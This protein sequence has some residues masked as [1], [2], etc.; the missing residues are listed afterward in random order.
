MLRDCE[1]WV[2]RTSFFLGVEG[3]K[4][5]QDFGVNANLGGR[6]AVNTAVPVFDDGI[7]VQIGTA[8]NATANAVR[9]NELLGE[10]RDRFQNYST[11]GLFQRTDWGWNWG[12]GYDFLHQRSYDD[13]DL[14]QLRLRT[15]WQWG[16]CDEFGVAASIPLNA[17]RGA[18]GA[19]DV[20]LQAISQQTLFWRH[21]WQSGTTTTVWGGSADGHSEDNA[22]TGF[23]PS[24]GAV[25]VAG[26][27][28]TAPLNDYFSLYG[29]TNL[30]MPPDTGTVDAFL[31]VEVYLSPPT[32]GGLFR[33]RLSPYLPL[34]GS[35]SFPVDLRRR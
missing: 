30:M 20:E 14:S 16:D 9:V 35:T 33:H 13:F 22:V 21:V 27:D 31:G 3:S 29:E 10:E 7:G 8:L 12:V 24:Q 32:R 6:V 25:F 17:S 2:D 23:S 26:A 34:A 1:T 11:I 28:F 15:S 18:Y 19:I 4:Q 5:P